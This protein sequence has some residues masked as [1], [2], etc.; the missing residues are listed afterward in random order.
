LSRW[1]LYS[2]PNSFYSAR[3]RAVAYL[4]GIDLQIEAPPGGLGSARFRAI[5]PL[6][7]VPALSTPA[8]VL[9][10]S[11]IICEYL[12]QVYPTPSLLPADAWHR[13]RLQLICRYIDLYLAPLFTPIWRRLRA[14]GLRGGL[15]P[16]ERTQVQLRFT[17]FASL[18]GASEH[19][20]SISLVDC[21]AVPV[22]FLYQR[23]FA[24]FG[25]EDPL[26]PHPALRARFDQACQ[27][28]ALV[29]VLAEMDS[30]VRRR[31]GMHGS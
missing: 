7:K 6:G 15:T 4:K 20:G 19:D 24:I 13:A 25:E 16:D 9:V 14:A 3:C 28:P 31:T 22:V 12:E 27:P 2:L 21:A 26:A 17:E 30:E 1:V 29:R 8:G 10:E 18:L 23:L 11:Q 5:S